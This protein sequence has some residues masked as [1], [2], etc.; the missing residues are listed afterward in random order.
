ML[1]N[2]ARG[3]QRRLESVRACGLAMPLRRDDGNSFRLSHRLFL[4]LIL[5]GVTRYQVAPQ[6][7]H[8]L[9]AVT[10]KFYRDFRVSPHVQGH[11]HENC[12]IMPPE[13]WISLR[14]HHYTHTPLSLSLYSRAKGEL[15]CVCVCVCFSQHSHHRRSPAS[16][17][18]RHEP[19]QVRCCGSARSSAPNNQQALSRT[20]HSA[21][22]PSPLPPPP[23]T[24]L[25]PRR[26]G[27]FFFARASLYLPPTPHPPVNFIPNTNLL[28]MRCGVSGDF[29]SSS[30]QSRGAPFE[31]DI[32]IRETKCL[33]FIPQ[34]I[35]FDIKI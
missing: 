6:A 12:N 16:Q 18:A 4:I 29:A 20:N 2:I 31:T 30:Y 15:C 32:H 11:S 28:L 34:E 35:L 13:D 24:T 14:V 17:R 10:L 21:A 8:L 1:R 7:H 3:E 27:P 33:F 25:F 19:D 5:L 22:I 9:L 26:A 23:T